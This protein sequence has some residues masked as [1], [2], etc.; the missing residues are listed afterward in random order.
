MRKW[1]V[2]VLQNLLERLDHESASP[3]PTVVEEAVPPP[4]VDTTPEVALAEAAA[5][6]S[7][8]SASSPEEGWMEESL[9]E[10]E[11][12]EELQ[13]ALL[14]VEVTLE[15]PLLVAPMVE[16]AMPVEEPEPPPSPEPAPAREP[17][18]RTVR[19][20]TPSRMPGFRYQ[21]PWE[22]SGGIPFQTP[23]AAS[24][25]STKI[26]SRTPGT[27]ATVPVPDLPTM[28]FQRPPVG[29]G[30]PVPAISQNPEHGQEEH[31]A[32]AFHPWQ[33]TPPT[34]AFP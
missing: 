23:S 27:V 5:E 14:D 32:V 12:A 6:P 10:P 29:D 7:D 3:M 15:D 2:K 26:P 33:A 34:V 11:Q 13:P 8:L 18:K 4:P 22:R 28:P 20:E 31:R 21:H 30:P 25:E 9:A 17:P 24:P 16:A 19:L 1:T